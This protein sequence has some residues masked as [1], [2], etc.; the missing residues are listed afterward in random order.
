MCLFPKTKNKATGFDEA[1][2][3]QGKNGNKVVM[4]WDVNQWFYRTALEGQV[5]LD[6]SGQSPNVAKSVLGWRKE[7][8]FPDYQKSPHFQCFQH[9]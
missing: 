5:V 4:D 6:A 7:Y 2:V 1:V 8:L 9:Q 3:V